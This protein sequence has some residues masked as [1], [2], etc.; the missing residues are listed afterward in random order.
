MSYQIDFAPD[1]KHWQLAKTIKRVSKA[2]DY[3]VA[4]T[5]IRLQLSLNPFA[6]FRLRN[7]DKILGILPKT[8]FPEK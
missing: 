7:G 8:D 5:D 1:G 3:F 4:N 2:W 6:K